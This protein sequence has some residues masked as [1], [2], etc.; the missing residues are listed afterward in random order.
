MSL[1]DAIMFQIL[2]ER[3]AAFASICDNALRY[4]FLHKMIDGTLG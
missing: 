1:V 2:V 3:R 4:S